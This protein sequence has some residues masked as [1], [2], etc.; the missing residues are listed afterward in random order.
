MS[1]RAWAVLSNKYNYKALKTLKTA[2]KW[3]MNQLLTKPGGFHKDSMD[4]KKKKKSQNVQLDTGPIHFQSATQWRVMMM[5][6]VSFSV[7]KQFWKLIID[8]SYARYL[9]FSWKDYKSSTML[10]IE[11][12]DIRFPHKGDLILPTLDDSVTQLSFNVLQTRFH[13][14][15]IQWKPKRMVTLYFKDQFS[16]LTSWLLACLSIFISTYKAHI[17]AL[18]CMTLFRP[19][20]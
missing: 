4:W 12:A 9:S 18:F 14:W 2:S 3:T 1:Y 8:H 5:V 17:Y 10:S 11:K 19:H 7:S 6:H 20:T 15:N 16:L 13:E